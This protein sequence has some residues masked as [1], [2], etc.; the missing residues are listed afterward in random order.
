MKCYNERKTDDMDLPGNMANVTV[1]G[2]VNASNVNAAAVAAAANAM[3]AQSINCS[4]TAA[5]QN[6][7][8]PLI[9]NE[10]N[11]VST[12]LEECLICSDLKRDTIFKVS[13]IE[14]HN[15]FCRIKL[16]FIFMVSLKIF[17]AL[18]TCVRVR[19]MCATRKEM[20]NLSRNGIIT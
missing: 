3:S 2:G 19:Y 7:S 1:V 16:Y 17:S 9:E 18:W 12:S 14:C 13:R 10:P 8:I 20:S 4:M 6:N 11:V 5:N 15:F